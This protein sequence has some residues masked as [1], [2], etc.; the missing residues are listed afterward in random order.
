MKYQSMSQLYSARTVPMFSSHCQHDLRSHITTVTTSNNSHIYTVL[1]IETQILKNGTQGNPA[2]LPNPKPGFKSSWNPGFEFF[3]LLC[4]H[5]NSISCN[6]LMRFSL[7]TNCPNVFSCCFYGKLTIE[8]NPVFC[9]W[10][11]DW[12]TG[13]HGSDWL[14]AVHRCQWSIRPKLMFFS[15]VFIVLTVEQ[16]FDGFCSFHD[17]I[18]TLFTD[19][20]YRPTC[21]L[22][23]T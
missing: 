15:T 1:G 8:Q 9:L 3:W 10:S 7:V 16:L 5:F 11:R 20:V 18:R 6:G 22:W 14:T 13:P 4:V 23:Q 19:L 12:V 17:G 2:I 21:Q